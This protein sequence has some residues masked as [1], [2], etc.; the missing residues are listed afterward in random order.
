MST[1]EGEE[2]CIADVH[3]SLVREFRALLTIVVPRD[4]SRCERVLSVFKDQGL[5]A[6]QWAKEVK[7]CTKILKQFICTLSGYF[8]CT[9]CSVVFG[10]KLFVGCVCLSVA[11]WHHFPS[12]TG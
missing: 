7:S 6:E 4:P 11:Q 5:I 12:L 3:S 2:A 1:H 8:G 9:C 10:T